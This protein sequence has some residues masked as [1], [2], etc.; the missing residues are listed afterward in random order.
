MATTHI[1]FIPATPNF[2]TKKGTD[3]ILYG[4]IV[5][6]DTGA[7]VNL[8]AG[9]VTGELYKKPRSANATLVATL[10]VA[11]TTAAAGHVTMTIADTEAIWANNSEY[12][13]YIVWTNT[14]INRCG[15]YPF[16]YT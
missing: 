3:K 8:S 7:A 11:I 12:E 2:G 4:Y 1:K 10:T 15:P 6:P 13:L 14:Q 5:N 16:S 9:T